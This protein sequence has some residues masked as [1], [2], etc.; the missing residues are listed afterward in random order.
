MKTVFDYTRLGSI[1]LKNRFMVAPMTRVSANLQGVPS[2]E[3]QE[4]YSAFAHGGFGGIITEGI[5][6]DDL[7]SKSYPNQP[8]L[9]HPEHINE[10][11]KITK[12]VHEY[13]AR[14]FA[15][16]MHGGSI[17][18][19]LSIT[20]APS[21]IR[22]LGQK[23]PHYG[24]GSGPFPVAAEMT[25]QD[26]EDTITGFVE[27]AKNALT[28]G[29]D[30]VELHSANGYLL[31][32]FITPYLNLRTDEY[33]G[34]IRNMTRVVREIVKRIKAFAPSGFIVGLRIS[35]GKVN[36]LDYRWPGGSDTARAILHEI[37][38]MPIDYLHVAAEHAGWENE[39]RYP[40]GSF[41]TGL[42]KEIL[43]C[44]VIANGKLHDLD[45]AEK[46]LQSGQADLIAI[47]KLALANPDF[48]NK[49]RNNEKVIP[50]DG[51]ML[52]TNPSLFSTE[53]YERYAEEYEASFCATTMDQNDV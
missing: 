53:K 5:Y 15:Q 11:Q 49:I 26:I 37:G 50:F 10:W 1:E 43:D 24:G 9:V 19:T 36:H 28:S 4:Y 47:G 3:M 42:A 52:N 48:V 7:Y 18:Q 31:D 38:K 13:D 33:G 46:L 16:L 41:L 30:G 21:G 22:P 20:K 39:V 35:E 45:L 17:S 40:D 2:E 34:V 51:A 6:T 27:A 23:M 14:I 8:G 32:Q 29:F 25:K 44:P 12:K